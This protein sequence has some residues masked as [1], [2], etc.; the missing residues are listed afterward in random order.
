MTANNPPMQL[1]LRPPPYT[2]HS[3]GQANHDP[4]A[5]NFNS[6]PSDAH[7]IAISRL[8]HPPQFGMVQPMV[9]M[10]PYQNQIAPGAPLSNNQ[11]HAPAADQSPNNIH[12]SFTNPYLHSTN[13]PPVVNNRH[14]SD[15]AQN[16]Q[17]GAVTQASPWGE[18]LTRTAGPSNNNG[19]PSWDLMY[20][21]Q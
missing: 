3:L 10:A 15:H 12:W 14:T 4:Q 1:V 19:L 11:M 18:N 13:P 7:A 21:R 17:H 6:M 16:S 2:P 5:F 20:P 9:P 8:Q